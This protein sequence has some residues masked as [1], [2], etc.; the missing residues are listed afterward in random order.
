MAQVVVDVLEAVQVHEQH[1]QLVLV[2]LGQGDALRQLLEEQRAV[3]QAGQHVVVGQVADALLGAVGLDDAAHPLRQ[4]GVVDGLGNIV[5][6]AGR[7]R[8]LDRG[9]VLQRGDH[10]HRDRCAARHILQARAGGE[11]VHHRHHGVHQDH[12]GLASFEHGQRLHAV[13]RLLDAEAVALQGVA[14]GAAGAAVVVDHQHLRRFFARCVGGVVAGTDFGAQE[15]GHVMIGGAQSRQQRDDARQLV[16]DGQLFGLAGQ[17]C[18]QHRAEVAGRALERVG[19]GA[20]GFDV[21][22]APRLFQ[23]VEI[24]RRVFEEGRDGMRQGAAQELAQLAEQGPVDRLGGVVGRRRVVLRGVRVRVAVRQPF[25]EFVAQ[26]DQRDRLG[27]VIVHAGGQA[28]FGVAALGVGGH[29]HQRRAPAQRLLGG[30]DVRRRLVTIHLRHAAIHQDQVVA[31]ALRRVDRLAAVEGELALAAVHGQHGGG[32]H[33]V[34]AVVLGHQHAVQAA[35]R[36]GTGQA[37]R[38][39]VAAAGQQFA[40]R[41]QQTVLAQRLAQR[42][43]ARDAA[44]AMPAVAV[45]QQQ[46][47]RQAARFDAA[48]QVCAALV[49]GGD[50]EDHQLIGMA[51]GVGVFQLGQRHVAGRADVMQRAVPRQQVLQEGAHDGAVVDRQHAHAAQAGVVG[52]GGVVRLGGRHRRAAYG[53]HEAGAEAG[54]AADADVAAQQADQLLADRQA[55]TG[56]AVAPR[57]RWFR[58]R[59]RDEQLPLRRFADADAGVAHR[60]AQAV[61][62]GGAVLVIRMLTSGGR[63][64]GRL[65][66][67]R[68]FAAL[69]ELD[70]VAEQVDQNLPQP[71]RVAADALGRA[72]RQQVAD[73]D[74]FLLRRTGHQIDHFLDQLAQVE[75]VLFQGQLAGFHLGEIE[76]D[77]RKLVEEVIDLV[78]RPAQQKGIDVGYLLAPGTPERVSGDS[79]RLRQIL[80]NLLG[81]AV[82]FT[83]RGEVALHVQAAELAAA[84]GEHA[85]DKDGAATRHGL[86]F[87]VRDTGIGISEPAQR[88]LFVSFAQS[89]PSTTRRYGGTGLGLAICKQ[90]VG[91]LGGDIGVSSTPGFGT[92]FVF[93][94]G[95]TPV[96]TAPPHD[97]GLSG[98]RVLAVDNSAIVRAFLQDLLTR[99]GALHHV[100][101]SGDMALA[102]LKH[103]DAAG[104]PYQLVILDVAA[105]DERGA[106]LASRIEASGLTPHL[107]LL[108]RHGRHGGGSVSG[109]ATLGKPLRQDRLLAALRELLA[110]RRH[111]ETARLPGAAAPGRLYRVLVAEDN[112]T[113]QMVAAAMLAMHGCQC[114][115]AFNGREAVDAAQRQ[116]YDLILM[117]CSMPEMDGYEA[118][119]HIRAAEEALGRRTPL[120]AMTAN[121]QRGDAEKCLAAG[122]DD[123]LAKPITL[124]ELRHKLDKWLPH[125]DAHAYATEHDAAPADN[126]LEPVDR[127]LFGKLRE[128]L[129]STLAHA[130]TPFLEDT[131]V[132]LDE[133]EQALRSGDI[134]T[135]R[136]RAHALKGSSGNLG[137]VLL[138]QLAGQAEQLAIAHQLPRIVALLPALRAAYHDVAGFLSAEIGPGHDAA[139]APREEAPQVL[140]VDDDRST[141]STLRYT[142]QRDGFRVE[143]AADGVQ[144]LAMLKRCQPDVILMDAVMP[145]M[146]GFTACARLQ[147]MPGGAS[148]PVL[149]ITALQD[150]SS[151]ERAFAAGASDYI[152]KPI[153]Y[154]VLSQ[155]VRR[156]IEANRAEKRIRHLAYNDVLTGLPNRT[157]FF[158]QLAQGIVLAESNQHQLAVLFM[159]L[160]RFQ[161]VNDNLGHDVGDRLLAAVAQRVRNSVR[162]IDT[163][164]RLGGDEFTVVLGDLD[165]PAA[166]A[167]AAQ[168]ICRVLASPFQIDGHDIFVTSSVGIAMYPHDGAD[169]ATLVKHADSAMYRAK[170]GNTGFQFYEAS[171]E[172][173]ISEHVRLESDLRRALEQQQLQVYY[174]P[175]ATLAD[176]RIVAMEAL[177]RWQHPQRGMVSPMEF[178][179]L[180]EETGLI[181]PLGDWVLRSACAQLQRWIAQGLP[182]LRVAVNLSVRQ[183]LQKDFAAT[184]EAALADTGLAPHLLELEI[185]EGTLMEH[186]ADTLSALHRLRELGVRL[187]IDDFGTGYSSL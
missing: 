132:Y 180:A 150:N 163:V 81:N 94:I 19:A 84:A 101:A 89:E 23:L 154:A 53:E 62:R 165:G 59:E 2:G 162:N 67:Q 116:R 42:G 148:I 57:G 109:H 144:A 126:D 156:I 136:A 149:M 134:E 183:L 111:T 60:E 73:I 171:M 122:M 22:A 185:T 68:H 181:N 95:C 140:V 113:N 48:G 4:H 80:I 34:G 97:A 151:V 178:I 56:A 16:G 146:D 125:G 131:P 182:P 86:R 41:G 96:S 152:P 166:A 107:L 117:D 98:V 78:A 69:G 3:R 164:A 161:Y 30:A 90:L 92:S 145:V 104:H 121:T 170:R 52:R 18:Q 27:Q 38:F 135:A 55:K 5:A 75:L 14:Q 187:S 110:G 37:R 127:A 87:A 17:L 103:A 65:D 160:D 173:S 70:G 179:P 112:R 15:A 13:G 54:R 139:D 118:T 83:E 12:V 58:L 184:V 25:V 36:G 7:E 99:H 141:R 10:Q 91:L 137:A 66:M 119:A 167:T 72:R 176:G 100:G 51:G 120:V 9:I 155:R 76:F 49:G 82:K 172:L 33:L 46:V 124:I 11:T 40:Q 43:V 63:Q 21:A 79:L 130:V 177:V 133:L 20:R 158:E 108:D 6:G 71:Q 147:D 153:H 45:E 115:F 123:Y 44:A 102:E 105:I 129:G 142:L 77:L 47:R 128:L 61:A 64:F 174:Q 74:A 29:R 32:H 85:D 168:P 1:G 24:D 50:V 93:T 157:L 35:G 39:G 26:L 88:Q 169:V 143:E 106:D 159:D 114:E 8:A 186:A 28:F 175:Q 138:A 31:L